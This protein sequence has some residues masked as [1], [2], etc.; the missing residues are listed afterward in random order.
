MP[1]PQINN[2]NFNL[3]SAM[4]GFAIGAA[5]TVLAFVAIL[6]LVFA[7]RAEVT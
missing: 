3:A 6:M 2:G 7:R 5:A 4:S 1:I